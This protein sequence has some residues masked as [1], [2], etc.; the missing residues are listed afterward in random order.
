[1]PFLTRATEIVLMTVSEGGDGG[2]DA[3]RLIRNLAWHGLRAR[4]EHLSA[5]DRDPAETLLAAAAQN[6]GLLVMGGYGQ[7]GCGNGYL[8]ASP[9]AFWKV[10]RC[11]CCSLIERNASRRFSALT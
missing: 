2:N 6:A 4:R 9:G 7:A 10:H 8:A 3:Y 1:M 5:D 11:R